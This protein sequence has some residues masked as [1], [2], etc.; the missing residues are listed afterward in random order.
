MELDANG[1]FDYLQS[2][3][4]DL[5]SPPPPSSLGGAHLY[6]SQWMCQNCSPIISLPMLSNFS[7]DGQEKISQYLKDMIVTPLVEWVERTVMSCTLKWKQMEEVI[8]NRSWKLHAFWTSRCPG[9][10]FR[11]T[12]ATKRSC[13]LM[14]GSFP[15]HWAILVNSCRAIGQPPL[16]KRNGIWPRK[17][18]KVTL[19]GHLCFWCGSHQWCQ[20]LGQV[21]KG[22]RQ[23]CFDCTQRRYLAIFLLFCQRILSASLLEW[24]HMRWLCFYSKI[25]DWF[26]RTPTVNSHIPQEGIEAW[27]HW[28]FLQPSGR[29][30]PSM[31]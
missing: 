2:S 30:A 23:G 6:A 7:P 16:Q 27:R 15:I 26:R 22:W 21:W 11:P 3:G 18:N 25:Q 4:K 17:S 24:S 14:M 20:W 19:Q 29:Y 10:I 28:I 5:E 1:A 8:S 12:L 9:T 31:Q 13:F